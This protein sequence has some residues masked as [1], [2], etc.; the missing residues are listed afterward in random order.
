MDY[1]HDF[2]ISSTNNVQELGGNW[3]V[4]PIGVKVAPIRPKVAPI[5]PI[6]APIRSKVAPFTPNQPKKMAL[7]KQKRIPEIIFGNAF[8]YLS[9]TKS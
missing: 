9:K 7:I 2:T 5:R 6:V 3:I 1:L 4:A 8:F